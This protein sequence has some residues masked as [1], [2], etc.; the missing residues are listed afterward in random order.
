MFLDYLE[1][2]EELLVLLVGLERVWGKVE[3]VGLL[4]FGLRLIFGRLVRD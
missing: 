3:G 2:V 1:K 4:R